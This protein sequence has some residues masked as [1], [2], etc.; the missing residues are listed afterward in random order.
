MPASAQS[1]MCKRCSSHIDLRDYAITTT[2]SKNFRTKGRFVIEETGYVLNTDTIATD[3][4]LKGR[5]IGKL[6][7]EHSLEIH[8]TA[9]IKGSFSA[10]RLV[11]PEG[12][13]FRWLETI[14]IPTTEVAGEL[15]ANLQAAQGVILRAT[16][17]FFGDIVAPNLVVESG[18][19]FVGHAHIRPTT[20]T[21]P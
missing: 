7:A 3:I 17:R 20:H 4:V 2:V 19:V 10:E 18:A 1:S 21:P 5:F 13:R 6:R 16:A 15:V 9:A 11:I 14:T 12:E 8:S